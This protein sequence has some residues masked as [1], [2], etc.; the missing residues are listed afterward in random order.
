M[1]TLLKVLFNL[2]D[3]ETALNFSDFGIQK[4]LEPTFYRLAPLR[5]N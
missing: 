4:Q 3:F 1:L 5:R 2:S